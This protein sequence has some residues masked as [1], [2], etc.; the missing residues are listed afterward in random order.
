MVGGDWRGGG[1]GG[2]RVCHGEVFEDT[3]EHGRR[4]FGEA[5]RLVLTVISGR[6]V[7]VIA[8]LRFRRVA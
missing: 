2:Y 4:L 7:R 3:A 1:S 6:R 5:G 8:L